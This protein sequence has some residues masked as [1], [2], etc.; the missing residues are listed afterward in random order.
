MKKYYFYL[1]ATITLMLVG[2]SQQQKENESFN[3]VGA[4]V[5][6]GMIF[7][8]GQEYNPNKTGYTR[9]KIYDEDSTYY[10]VEIISRNGD[11]LFNPHEKA[12]FSQ[13]DS[14]YIE[15][16][17]DT[18][19]KIINDSVFT[20]VWNNYTE[21]WVRA[22]GMS[23]EKIEEIKN[24]FN[25]SVENGEFLNSYI[26][27]ETTTKQKEEKKTL[28]VILS[29]LVVVILS[30]IVYLIIT[31][32]SKRKAQKELKAILDENASHTTEMTEMLQK[33]E[34]DFFGSDY[35]TA[36]HKRVA[37]GEILKKADWEEMSAQLKEA[38]P[39]FESRLSSLCKMSD[40]EMQVCMLLKLRF[41]PSEIA[42]VIIKDAS[43]I[44][45]I[46]G[47]LYQKVFGKK[48][49]AKDWDEFLKTL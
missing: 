41:S 21:V 18:P 8:N 4:W 38:F 16:G 6:E 3:I 17:R 5:L 26:T 47:R 22:N 20:T 42:T 10:T 27:S 35:Y 29:A 49:G 31:L 23:A 2:C 19:F 48:G 44:S 28:Y 46:R 36:L 45:S 24:T 9:C 43:T 32:R 30:V 25:S 15:N 12:K 11:I 13:H 39:K 40:V 1:I 37:N 14:I 34:N 7:P 33:A